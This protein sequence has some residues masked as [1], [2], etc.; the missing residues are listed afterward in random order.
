MPR[1]NSAGL[2]LVCGFI[3]VFTETILSPFY[4]QFF[5]QVF[6][7]ADLALTGNYVA[8]CRLTVLISA[9]LWGFIARKVDPL[10]LLIFGQLLAAGATL[11]LSQARDL[12]S[13]LLLSVLLL[14]FKSSYFLFYSLLIELQGKD[15]QAKTVGQVQLVVHAALIA[16]ALASAWVLE[17]AK[18]L[19]MFAFVALLDLLQVCL[20]VLVFRHRRQSR[21]SDAPA[22]VVSAPQQAWALPTIMAYGLLILAFSVASN[23]VRP[24][25][26]VYSTDVL[27]VDRLAAAWLYLIPSLMAFAVFPLL[28]SAWIKRIQVPQAY[29]LMLATLVL[30]LVWQA[31]AQSFYQLLLARLLF[32]FSLLFAQALLEIYLF[33]HAQHSPHWYFSLASTVQH[34]GQLL[35]PLLAAWVVLAWGLTAPFWL[36]ASILGVS[37]LGIYWGLSAKSFLQAQRSI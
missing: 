18:P 3:F 23:A 33:A 36:A 10:K 26:T 35:A 20:C 7:V 6:G 16:S 19:Q 1:L 8:M 24:Y 28:Q 13:F 4:P 25:L 27:G 5:A 9:P 37:A 21:G 34:G 11:L 17:L 14:L 12:N 32:G 30:S 2:L 22:A 31:M 29:S 15:R